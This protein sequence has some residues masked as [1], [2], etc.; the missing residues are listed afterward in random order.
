VVDPGGQ[1][2][3]R[4]GV[5]ASV[6]YGVKSTVV[7]DPEIDDSRRPTDKW[8]DILPRWERRVGRIGDLFVGLWASSLA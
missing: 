6:L 1:E 8:V 4:V 7:V 5:G 2:P 3:A